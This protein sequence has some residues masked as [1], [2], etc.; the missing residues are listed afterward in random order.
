MPSDGKDSDLRRVLYGMVATGGRTAQQR[1]GGDG[2]GYGGI[3]AS[4]FSSPLPAFLARNE[5]VAA[6]TEFRTNPGWEKAKGRATVQ[7]AQVCAGVWTRQEAEG[8][9]WEIVRDGWQ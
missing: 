3:L 5:C 7:T 6:Q 9:G 8:F 4:C 1:K 2:Y